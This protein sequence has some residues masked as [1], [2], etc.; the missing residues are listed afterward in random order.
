VRSSR[1]GMG[2]R[3]GAGAIAA[4]VIGVLMAVIAAPTGGLSRS[5]LGIVAL[6]L[7]LLL[8]GLF[9]GWLL[10][11]GRLRV[12]FG[13]GILYWV[14][15]FPLARLS[16]EFMVGSETMSVSEVLGDFMIF[17]ALVGGAFGL[18]FF[19]LHNQISEWLG[20]EET[21]EAAGS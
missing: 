4:L 15:A 19:L 17:Q 10:D 13:P 11:S 12:G 2:G 20:E 14:V 16:Q 21:G 9:Y 7:P 8:A 5:V 1:G 3:A 6:T 18:G